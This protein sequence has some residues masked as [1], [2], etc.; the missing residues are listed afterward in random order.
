MAAVDA[1]PEQDLGAL[2]RRVRR[3]A[4]LSQRELAELAGVQQVLVSRI[5]S[6]KVSNPS[7]RTLE[8][9]VGAAGGR[10]GVDLTA[11]QPIPHEDRRDEGDRHYPAH[12]DVRDVNSP[13]DWGGAWW[14]YW[15]P[16]REKD[17]P[18]RVPDAT[19]DLRRDRRDQR[20]LRQQTRRTAV[21]RRPV[22]RAWRWVA[23]VPE[24]E[25]IGELRAARF[26][27]LAALL[28]VYVS[29]ARRNAGVGRRLVEEFLAEAEREGVTEV[30]A[31]S[32]L[33]GVRFLARFGFREVDR[34]WR[35]VLDKPSAS[36]SRP[37][38]R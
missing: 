19:Y 9:L 38:R 36:R 18:L 12:L 35:I 14:A 3:E 33:G 20:R 4:D 17:W 31:I 15:Y 34:L 26:D 25:L 21:V 2:L 5:E 10:L 30:E 24:G 37:R 22:A 6:G 27:R 13:K 11:V 28:W 32:G 23:D 1:P 29:P 16:L 7:F 8:R